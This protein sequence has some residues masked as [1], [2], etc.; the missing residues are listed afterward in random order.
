MEFRL[1]LVHIIRFALYFRSRGD[2]VV[3]RDSVLPSFIEMVGH[4]LDKASIRE[5]WIRQ[6]WNEFLFIL[7]SV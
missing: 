6:Y 2:A 1:V 5:G 3:D 7:L 4:V